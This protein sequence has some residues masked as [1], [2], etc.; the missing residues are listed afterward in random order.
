MLTE[1]THALAIWKPF[2]PT[3]RVEF[4]NLT[5]DCITINCAKWANSSARCPF[6]TAHDEPSAPLCLLI[7]LGTSVGYVLHEFQD[8]ATS[9][10]FNEVISNKRCDL[11]LDAPAIG[12]QS[13]GL[14]SG[15]TISLLPAS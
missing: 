6:A 2:D 15:A 11:A 13:T 10:V 3:A 1:K 9:N 8:I 4:Y 12:S 14:L 5:C 7:K